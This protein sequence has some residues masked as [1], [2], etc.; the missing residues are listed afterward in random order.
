MQAQWSAFINGG[1]P[2]EDWP[3]YRAPQRET[4]IFDVQPH[5]EEAPMET[6]RQAWESYDMLE[7]GTGR[8]EI[9]KLLGFMPDD[10]NRG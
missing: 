9:L 5:I 4:M 8:P 10:H 3:R 2:R 7:W 1:A 6:R